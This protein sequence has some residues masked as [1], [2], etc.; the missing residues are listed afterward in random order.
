MRARA[1]LL[2]AALLAGCASTTVGTTGRPLEAPLCQPGEA[3]RTVY[4]V[5][6]PEWRPDQKEPAQ[7]E[8]LARKGIE[9][10]LAGTPC[11]AVAGVKRFPAGSATPSDEELLQLARGATPPADLAVLVVVHELGPI[12]LI[13][14]PALVEGGT[15]VVI[16]VRVLETATSAILAESRTH[17][18]NGG[19]FVIK[20]TGSLD[21]DMAAALRAALLPASGDGP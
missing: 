21:R 3:P 16:D 8:A 13:G 5:W 12:L 1:L 14:I 10:F 2:A 7:R 9:E 20:G 6:G 15:E 19:T 4:F 11:L 18:K 17:W